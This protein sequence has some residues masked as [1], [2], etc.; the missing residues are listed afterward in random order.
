MWSKPSSAPK[1]KPVARLKKNA[2]S[3]KSVRKLHVVPPKKL[4]PPRLLQKRRRLHLKSSHSLL[5]SAQHLLRRQAVQMHVR[6][7]H[8][9][10]RP[11]RNQL[12]LAHHAFAEPMMTMMIAAHAVDQAACQHVAR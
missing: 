10:L 12:R 5:F 11:H 8:V 4:L 6:R 2:V 3:L 9:L 1:M 7:V